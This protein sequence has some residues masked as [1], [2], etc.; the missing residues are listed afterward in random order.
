MGFCPWA[1]TNFWFS[2]N[3]DYL[4]FDAWEPLYCPLPYCPPGA[5]ALWKADPR[6]NGKAAMIRPPN[7][8]TIFEPS[9]SPDGRWFAFVRGHPFTPG[10]PRSALNQEVVVMPADGR[11]EQSLIT[12]PVGNPGLRFPYG[13]SW[14]PRG[15]Q[16]A[17]LERSFLPPMYLAQ[18]AVWH[19]AT[20]II[21]RFGAPTQRGQ[22]PVW[23]PDGRFLLTEQFGPLFVNQ[24]NVIDVQSG[25]ESILLPAGIMGKDVWHWSPLMDLIAFRGIPD[26]NGWP[27]VWVH[28]TGLGVTPAAVGTFRPGT[29]VRFRL[30]AFHHP[31]LRYVLGLALS[32]APGIPTPAGTIPLAVD[33]LLRTSL[34]GGPG[35]R[36]LTG[37]LDARGRADAFFRV[38]AGAGPLQGLRY[39]AAYV[40]LNEA[41]NIVLVSRARP[42]FVLG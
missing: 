32:D 6:D 12:Y 38:P 41:G 16:L 7:Y 35:F 5:T 34:A 15:D 14:S 36:N 18:L 23:S 39:F 30:E 26:P 27:Q 20:G 8:D 4:L 10:I 37:R 33:A 11:F 28:D 21:Q 3:S 42:V 31:G 2:P 25:Q 24:L 17:W 40:L 9:Q 13:P 19:Q 29:E 1:I 22:A